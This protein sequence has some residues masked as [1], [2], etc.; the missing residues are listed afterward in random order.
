MTTPA[1]REASD[2][3]LADGADGAVSA[4]EIEADI[5]R[6]REQVVNTV[7]ALSEKLDVKAQARHTVQNLRNPRTA[8]RAGAALV[9]VVITAG[10]VLAWRR[11]R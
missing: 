3:D 9:A 8:A 11:R 2:L 1:E 4:D 10:A 5:E 7:D 6:T